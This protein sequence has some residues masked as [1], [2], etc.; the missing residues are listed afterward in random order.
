MILSP[1][2]IF[3]LALMA[4][5]TIASQPT[6]ANTLPI[7]QEQAKGSDSPEMRQILLSGIK[8]DLINSSNSA[9]MSLIE[10]QKCFSSSA[11]NT[12]CPEFRNTLLKI[13]QDQVQL[14][15]LTQA[16]TWRNV[17]HLQRMSLTAWIHELDMEKLSAEEVA[18]F[19]QPGFTYSP[20]DKAMALTLWKRIFVQY[21]DIYLK[22]KDLTVDQQSC[23]AAKRIPITIVSER[24][25]QYF[26][27]IS[28][29]LVRI[30]PLLAFVTEDSLKDYNQIHAA[31]GKLIKFNQ[32]FAQ[33]VS[34]Y[35]TEHSTNFWSYLN[36]TINDHE[37]GLINFP[38][39]AQ[40]VIMSM[41]E[42]KHSEACSAWAGLE[43]Q[44]SLR[45][46]SSIGVGFSTAVIC[47]VGIWSGVGT[48]P[49]AAYCSFAMADGLWGGYRGFDDARL[50]RNS[51]YAGRV[52]TFEG[53]V[54]RGIRDF[55]EAA[56]LST[57]GNVVF[58]INIVGLLPVMKGV[59]AA[60]KGSKGELI[61]LAKLPASD[62][63]VSYGESNS[64][65][66]GALM[67]LVK[68][69]DSDPQL[70][71]SFFHKSRAIE[72]VRECRQLL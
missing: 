5:L 33:T 29:E 39:Q 55:E 18:N 31:F 62:S 28:A 17:N 9:K 40:N 34:G 16:L 59:S 42:E 68:K 25:R 27:Q 51:A 8:Q 52:F 10:A 58:L 54:S 22:E 37:M 21:S 4:A 63:A 57:Q 72:F 64:S 43:S 15:K 32:D 14:A 46:N 65:S 60:A 2:S 23:Q 44:K 66:I 61:A 56:Q 13:L 19:K 30:N 7:C 48:L 45:V 12:T 49:A 11:N 41:G 70:K 20:S 26:A 1:K 36:L 69:S 53:K 47:G 3:S 71:Q 24:V 35:E 67:T 6:F 38:N 50:S